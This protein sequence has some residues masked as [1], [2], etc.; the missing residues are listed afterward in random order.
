MPEMTI[1]ARKPSTTTGPVTGVARKQSAKNRPQK[2]PQKAPREPQNLTLSPSAVE[3][4]DLLF[5]V[6][7]LADD[8]EVLHCETA[9]PSASSPR[10]PRHHDSE[11]TA[12]AVSNLSMGDSWGRRG[13]GQ[14]APNAALRESGH[15]RGEPFAGASSDEM[16]LS[17]DAPMKTDSNHPFFHPP[18]LVR[19]PGFLA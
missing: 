8:A 18:R 4:D 2:P 5:G 12:I 13:A 1:V 17:G 7:A 6:I 3:T 19:R 14:V 11:N 9:P 15:R 10:L 16:T